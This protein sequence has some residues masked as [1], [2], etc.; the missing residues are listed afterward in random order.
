MSPL[1]LAAALTPSAP[2]PAADLRVPP[3]FTAHVYA[4]HTLANDIYTMT[5][6]DAGR[7]LVAGRGYVRVLTD[8][9]GDGTADRAIDLIDN[10]TDGP[11][12][13]FAEGDSLY[14]VAG[15]G[16][17]RYRGYNGKDK[18]TR[19]PELV[20]KVK[21]VGEHEA[22]QIRR[23]PDGWLYLLCGNMAGV[24]KATIT[25]DRSPVKDPVAGTLVRISPDGKTVEV[26]ADGFRNPYGFDFNPDGEP[27]T[28]DSDNERC[29][30]LPW[31][32]GCRFYHVVPGGNY[33]WRSPQFSQTWRKPPYFADVVAPICN[34]GRGSP[35]GVA[36][37]RHT[38]FPAA[39]RGGFFLADWTFGRVYHVPLM[40]KHSTYTG[41]SKVFAESIG[42]SGFAPTAVAVHPKTGELYVSIGGRGTRGGVYRVRCD[43]G[44]DPDP[45]LIRVKPRSLEWNDDIEKQCV[46]DLTG[47]NAAAR[48]RTLAVFTRWWDRA[49]RDKTV[50]DAMNAALG[51][52]DPLTRAAA[53]RAVV[54]MAVPVGNPSDP[55]VR[56]TLALAELGRDSEWAYKT[57]LALLNDWHT[58]AVVKLQAIRVVQLYFGDLTAPDA[59]GTVWEGYSLRHPP[60]GRIDQ[61]LTEALDN[62]FA[63][64]GPLLPREAKEI[65]DNP[66]IAREAAR[67]LAALQFRPPVRFRPFTTRGGYRV[68][69]RR[70]EVN[71]PVESLHY[72]ICLTRIS[73]APIRTARALVLLEDKARA[74]KLTRDR[75]WPLRVEELASYAGDF[76][77][78]EDTALAFYPEFGR[79]EHLYLIKPF[80]A[81]PADSAHRFIEVADADPDYGWTPGQV[82]LIGEALPVEEAR[83]V[84][85]KLWDRGGLE[86][87]VILA[88]A[89]KPEAADR[90]KF[91]AG[92]RSLDPVVVRAAAV[93]L[94]PMPAARR[95][96]DEIAAAI[97][98]LRR[99]PDDKAAA[100]AREAVTRLLGALTNRALGADPNVW[101]SWFTGVYP[102]HAAKLGGTDGFDAA[103]WKKRA[104]AID[105]ATGDP[106]AGKKVFTK[107]TCAACHDGG[108]AIGPS[109]QGVAKR[110]GRDDLLTAVL[111]PNKDV[112]PRYRPTQITT[113]DGKSFTGMIV[114][115]AVDGVILQTGPDTTVRIAGSNIEAR[116]TLDTSLMPVGLLDK[117]TD[118]EVADLLAYLRT[119]DDMKPK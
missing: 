51:N 46:A 58:P 41:S 6:D 28:Y 33:G 45:K 113:A 57:A 23:G 17:W 3:G 98:A 19:P 80:R 30:G 42:E 81:D 13:L 8:D 63:P 61:R 39:Y 73:P 89:R 56:A 62:L 76:V 47:T 96:P 12:G 111:D 49:P 27:F 2:P 14:V 103:A 107:A 108:R 77:K 43:K 18:L 55:Q 35:T 52:P 84:L 64:Q 24:T 87:A 79:P 92:L 106:A 86:D 97:R 50:Y 88:L 21:A 69:R 11:M 44:G 60:T 59:V 15:T 112:S 95:D 102:A 22:H 40:P 34:T 74:K 7:V 119:L 67:T 100:P 25:G 104:A 71:D 101:A 117:L 110:F 115:E 10:L 78:E 53:G 4:D 38:H 82:K 1:L 91:V 85:R 114:Y 32:E 16:L 72:L 31:Y 70:S 26:V 118:R 29:V 37:Y 20:L 116:R 105:W 90:A 109:L 75:H 66:A 99:L 48:R 65:T 83:P 9:D 93:A 5:I 54:A 36:C 68:I 94:A